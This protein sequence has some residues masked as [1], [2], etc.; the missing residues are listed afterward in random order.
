M[1]LFINAAVLLLTTFEAS[2]ENIVLKL[3][4]S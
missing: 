3:F 2:S 1:T 4:E